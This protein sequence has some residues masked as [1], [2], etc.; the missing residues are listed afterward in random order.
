LFHLLIILKKAN[1]AIKQSNGEIIF[2]SIKE[3]LDLNQ[4][5]QIKTKYNTKPFRDLFSN[6]Y[7]KNTLFKFFFGLY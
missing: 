6:N 4:F 5:K 1:I 3:S 2:N 7:R